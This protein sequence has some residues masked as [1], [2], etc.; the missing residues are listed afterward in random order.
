MFKNSLSKKII[1]GSQSARR[2]ELLRGLDID[3]EVKTIEGLT[4]TYPNNLEINKIPEYLAKQKAD[5]F[6]EFLNEETLLIT[7]DTIVVLNGKV[8]GK[9]KDKN[10]AKA[11]LQVLSGKTHEVI[12]G[13]CLTTKGQQ[14]IFSENTKVTFSNFSENEII[15]N[16]NSNDK[17][18]IL[19][20]VTLFIISTLAHYLLAHF[21]NCSIK[22]LR[23]SK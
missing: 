9:P 19:F 8:Y 22:S 7:A 3:F 14:K 15:R 23:F 4:E 6:M 18:T 16:A 13:V 12:T 2:Q 5:A 20:P 21:S 10:E 1:L 17:S 11:M